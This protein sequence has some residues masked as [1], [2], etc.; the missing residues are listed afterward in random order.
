MAKFKTGDLVQLKSGG[1]KMTV[2]TYNTGT[3]LACDWF[4]GNKHE[5]GVFQE[6][7]LQEFIEPPKARP[8]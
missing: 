5:E 4:A 2:R 7:Q 6:A 1:P 3:Y 8:L